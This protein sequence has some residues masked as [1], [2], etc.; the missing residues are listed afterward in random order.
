MGSP[1]L[2]WILWPSGVF[3]L[4]TI[5]RTPCSLL[6]DANLRI[7]KKLNEAITTLTAVDNEMN[8]AYSSGIANGFSNEFLVWLFHLQV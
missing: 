3:L 6:I 4:L 1:P 2:V 7:K 8:D 5:D